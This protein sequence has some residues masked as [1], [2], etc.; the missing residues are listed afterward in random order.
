MSKAQWT[1]LGIL[2][3]I[4]G[5]ELT[6][7]TGTRAALAA[8]AVPAESAKTP[9]GRQSAALALF[10]ALGAAALLVLAD[11]APRAAEIL[12]GILLVGVLFARQ[13]PVLTWLTDVTDWLN[14]MRANAGGGTPAGGASS[15]PAPGVPPARGAGGSGSTRK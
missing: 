13:D 3:A 11:F 6:F 5:L 8:I 4:L 9:Q 15:S 14:T 2:A 7:S 1:V 12:A 10:F